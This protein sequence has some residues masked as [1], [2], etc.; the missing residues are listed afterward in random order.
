MGWLPMTLDDAATRHNCC[1]YLSAQQRFLG[2]DLPTPC[3]TLTCP[4]AVPSVAVAVKNMHWADPW[5]QFNNLA[6]LRYRCAGVL[7]SYSQLFV[8]I[9]SCGVGY[10]GAQVLAM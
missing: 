5:S 9:K 4:P 3:C 2:G 8:V 1:L 10:T 7:A 6:R